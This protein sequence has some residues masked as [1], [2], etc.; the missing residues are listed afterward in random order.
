MMKVKDV[1]EYLKIHSDE[2][3]LK[4]LYTPNKNYEV[5]GVKMMDI[6]ALAKTIGKD[7]KLAMELYKTNI[8]EAMM[9][10]PM[11][12][13]KED[14]SKE[15]FSDWVKKA[16]S[17]NI[18]S[19]G[20]SEILL[21]VSGYQDLLKLWIKEE[22]DDLI[23][24]GFV[25]M[26][27]YFRKESLANI[28]KGLGFEALNLVKEKINEVNMEIANAMNNTVVMAGLYVPDLVEKAIEVAKEI[29]FIMPLKKK[30]QCNIQS[31][32]D[33]IIRYS[34]DPKFSRVKKIIKE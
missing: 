27:V 28:D 2:K 19:Q 6:R 21:D 15:I 16:N 9:L 20:L 29:G 26:S 4:V 11:I 18:V 1:N 25:L 17:S 8:Y 14:I 34:G 22:D 32:L 7:S 30:N 33:Y 23:Y 5:L 3:T 12:I 24:G 10:S 31:A 13:K